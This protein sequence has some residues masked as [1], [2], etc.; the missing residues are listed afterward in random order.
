MKC[1]IMQPTYLPWS[2]YFNLMANVDR[3]VFLD[4]VQFER[5]SWQSRNRVLA[6]GKELYLTVP[7][8]RAARGESICRIRVDDGQDWRDRHLESL[9]HAYSRAPAGPEM[10]ALLES[11]LRRNVELLADLN[12][13]VIL[14][15]ADYLGLNPVTASA[16]E[17]NCG[18]RRSDH[19]AQLCRAVGCDEY[20]S[21]LGSRDYLMEDRFAEQSGIV[22][23]FQNY[24]PRV[25]AQAGCREFVSHLSIVDVIA[26]GGRKFAADYLRRGSGE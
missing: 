25:Y 1:A 26:H 7:V 19:L 22:L 8:H 24:V 14:G 12:R 2:G 4:D 20:L 3:F 15:L 18:G 6:R 10:L 13:N 23:T 16:S 5:R 11:L 9:R 17:A 21:P